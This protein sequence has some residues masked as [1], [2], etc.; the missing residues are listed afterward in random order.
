[1]KKKTLFWLHHYVSK[2][3]THKQLDHLYKTQFCFVIFFPL[4]SVIFWH[5]AC[6]MRW[7]FLSALWM[8]MAWCFSTRA[9]VATVLHMQP[10]VSS[11]SGVN[12]VVFTRITRV[13][14]ACRT[15]LL[16][17]LTSSG[18]L[19]LLYLSPRIFHNGL[20]FAHSKT[21]KLNFICELAG[22]FF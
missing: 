2:E 11:C 8:P 3:L 17:A 7:L 18:K 22:S 16:V 4:T 13:Q 10:C 20:H 9:S 5:E 12:V 15:W 19:L 1:M 14:F 21:M 6:P